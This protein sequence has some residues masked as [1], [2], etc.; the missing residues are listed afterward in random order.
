MRHDAH[1]VDQ[2]TS[3]T[4]GPQV[5]LI[6]IGDIDVARPGEA[7]DLAALV[8]SIQKFGVLQPLLVRPRA[9]RFELI[10]GARRLACPRTADNDRPDA[11]SV[12]P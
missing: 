10:A 3:R 2:L 4:I 6:P 8:K 12:P 11:R 5:R 9:G 1:Y 7:R